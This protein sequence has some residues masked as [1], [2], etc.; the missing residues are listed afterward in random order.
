[1]LKTNGEKL[2]LGQYHR[3]THNGRRTLHLFSLKGFFLFGIAV[4]K[5]GYRGFRAS[6]APKAAKAPVGA[7][8]SSGDGQVLAKE[9]LKQTAAEPTG[10][11]TQ[12]PLDRAAVTLNDMSNYHKASIAVSVLSHTANWHSEQA[13]TLRSASA[14]I[15]FE[16]K[17]M[18]RG[19]TTTSG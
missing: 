9:T 3:A 16:L 6:S 17:Q 13:K 14:T 15:D 11:Q 19:S 12:N 2:N 10:I 5:V 7:A 1:M 8:S 4:E 18:K